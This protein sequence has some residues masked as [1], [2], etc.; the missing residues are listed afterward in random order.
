MDVSFEELLWQFFVC[1]IL[2][3]FE[4]L[5][6]SFSSWFLK[7][8]LKVGRDRQGGYR[9][10]NLNV[11]HS[12][13]VYNRLARD[14]PRCLQHDHA[15]RT[16]RNY[17]TTH[18]ILVAMAA[19]R[20]PFSCLQNVAA[21]SGTPPAVYSLCMTCRN[22][23]GNIKSTSPDA[24]LLIQT[25]LR[26]SVKRFAHARKLPVRTLTFETTK[27]KDDSVAAIISGSAVLQIVLGDM[28][29]NTDI[30]IFCTNDAAAE[31][32]QHLHDIG[33]HDVTPDE[34]PDVDVKS[35]GFN[36]SQNILK[37]DLHNH[38]I[39]KVFRYVL[40]T[41]DSSDTPEA[42]YVSSCSEIDDD[43]HP[44]APQTIYFDIVQAEADVMD[45]RDLLD[46]FDLKCCAAYIDPACA[47][48]HIPDPHLTLQRQS[49][50]EQRH[51][52]LITGF[53]NSVW[54]QYHK[55]GVTTTEAIVRSGTGLRMP[56]PWW[57]PCAKAAVRSC[58][59]TLMS[60]DKSYAAFSL[61]ELR[62]IYCLCSRLCVRRQKYANRGIT[63]LTPMPFCSEVNDLFRKQK[64]RRRSS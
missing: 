52:S 58:E 11:E 47:T 51:A 49:K 13:T 9:C 37:L 20:L 14:T 43:V 18:L 16:D 8:P 1:L 41:D 3:L 25:S 54:E 64:L 44:K 15:S 53:A 17:G 57:L 38:K 48:F 12:I 19:A 24:A 21:L 28:W 40:C 10:P 35:Y 6:W 56:D 63:F 27:I 55:R 4:R 46:S 33:C 42:E 29:E 62:T 30:D 59:E 31:V 7:A 60:T 2:A 23:Y 26:M 39:D 5:L 34:F 32:R 36:L 22:M 61:S 45:A 50:S